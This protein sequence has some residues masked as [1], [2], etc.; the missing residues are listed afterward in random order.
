M[1]A[2]VVLSIGMVSRFVGVLFW[3]SCLFGLSIVRWLVRCSVL[4]SWL[5]VSSMVVGD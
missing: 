3:V 4:L 5:V 2:V 1:T